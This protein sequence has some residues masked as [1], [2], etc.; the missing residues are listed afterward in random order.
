MDNLY[1]FCFN[2][3]GQEKVYNCLGADVLLNAFE[4]YNA[5]IFAYGQTGK[6]DIMQLLQLVLSVTIP[7]FAN[8]QS[9]AIC[10]VLI[11]CHT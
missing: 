11:S 9:Q 3:I 2:I 5:C 8:S 4:G 10:T 7:R 6:S 1:L